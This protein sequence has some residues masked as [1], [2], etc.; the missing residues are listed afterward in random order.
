MTVANSEASRLYDADLLPVGVDTAP[1][2]FSR[3]RQ[4]LVPAFCRGTS[5]QQSFVQAFLRN[6]WSIAALLIPF[7][8]A[9]QLQ[10]PSGEGID[11]ASWPSAYLWH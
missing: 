6:S 1:C 7:K 4:S 10:L 3:Y 11:A 2:L 9:D 8:A 5:D